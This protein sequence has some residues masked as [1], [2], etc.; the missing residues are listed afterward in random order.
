M[1]LIRMDFNF[2]VFSFVFLNRKVTAVKETG[3]DTL[4]MAFPHFTPAP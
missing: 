2:D 1:R 3:V 4:R